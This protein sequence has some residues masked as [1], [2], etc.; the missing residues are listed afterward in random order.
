[1]RGSAMLDAVFTLAALMAGAQGFMQ[2]Q[3]AS[4]AT[5]AAV[6]ASSGMVAM[7]F[8]SHEAGQMVREGLLR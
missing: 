7:A 4:G 5:P 3:S 1:M 2:W 6:A 8:P